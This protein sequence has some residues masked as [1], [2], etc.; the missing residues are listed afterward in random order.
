MS[1]KSVFEIA[2]NGVNRITRLNF[3]VHKAVWRAFFKAIGQPDPW[4]QRPV[5]E[6]NDPDL[7]LLR[8]KAREAKS[9]GTLLTVREQHPDNGPDLTQLRAKLKASRS[10]DAMA[11]SRNTSHPS[12]DLL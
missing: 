7:Q 12:N 5:S 11:S 2:K 3:A 1:L 4:P 8:E 9:S 10:V 6:Y